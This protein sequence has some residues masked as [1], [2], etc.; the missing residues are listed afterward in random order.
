MES[1]RNS[2][3]FANWGLYTFLGST[4]FFVLIFSFIRGWLATPL[5]VVAALGILV[6]L[7]MAGIAGGLR[8]AGN[9][10]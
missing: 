5:Y 8:V 9:H 7:V 2:H 6:S 1:R 3:R 10:Q 4:A